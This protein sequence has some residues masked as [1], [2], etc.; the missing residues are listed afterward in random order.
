MF[1]LDNIYSQSRTNQ[2]I[3]YISSK[4]TIILL[5]ALLST[6]LCYDEAS[7]IDTEN[8]KNLATEVIIDLMTGYA[9]EECSRH[10]QCIELLVILVLMMFVAL[11][12]LFCITGECCS[13]T[14]RG[15]RRAG[16]IYAG[17]VIRQ[18]FD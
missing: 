6:A 10:P 4:L 7:D 15:M 17:A 18:A 5:L 9:I 16:T 8:G 1:L 2:R 3:M 12:V 13:P 11:L 14:T